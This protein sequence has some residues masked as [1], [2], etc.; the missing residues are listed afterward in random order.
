VK[1]K[2]SELK[3]RTKGVKSIGGQIGEKLRGLAGFD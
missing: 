3:E 1:H 2:N